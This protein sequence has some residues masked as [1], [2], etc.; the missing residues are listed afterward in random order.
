MVL[1]FI[2]TFILG[3]GT[4]LFIPVINAYGANIMK[5]NER[6]KISAVILILATLFSIL[7][8]PVAGKLY[9]INPKL[10]FLFIVSL[11]FATILLF[12]IS[13]K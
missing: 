11:Q 4:I 5:D 13:L 3:L 6:A 12:K 10:T 8:V 2:L 7:A 1:L 9:E